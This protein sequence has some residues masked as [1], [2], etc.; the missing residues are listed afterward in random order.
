ME[1]LKKTRTK[2][3]RP[4]MFLMHLLVL[5]LAVFSLQAITCCSIDDDEGMTPKKLTIQII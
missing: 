4:Q 5:T 2:L 3:S 1:Y